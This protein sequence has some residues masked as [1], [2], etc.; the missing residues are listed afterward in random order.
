MSRRKNSSPGFYSLPPDRVFLVSCCKFLVVICYGSRRKS[1]SRSVVSRLLSFVS[2]YSRSFLPVVCCGTI[3]SIC[4]T[5]QLRLYKKNG[6]SS[7]CRPTP[8]EQQK[9]LHSF[10]SI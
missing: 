8:V 6:F 9:I 2:G 4:K 1:A 3:C 10:P 5:W 7:D